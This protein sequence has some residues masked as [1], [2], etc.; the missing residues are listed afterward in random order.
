MRSCLSV[1]ADAWH[2]SELTF[3]GAGRRTPSW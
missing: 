3:E 2:V 1:M